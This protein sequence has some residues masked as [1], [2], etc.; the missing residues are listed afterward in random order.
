MVAVKGETEMGG[1][2]IRFQP[3][4]WTVVREA[5]DGS[6]D[7]LDRLIDTYWKPVYFFIRR[8]GNDIEASKD[9]TQSFFAA[10]LEKEFIRDVSSDKGKF[11]SFLLAAATHFL[12]NERDKARAQKRGGT[13]I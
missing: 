4:A 5:K 2:C 7:A 9:L 12:S 6:R 11:R 3:T 8:R 13:A 10:L 1:G